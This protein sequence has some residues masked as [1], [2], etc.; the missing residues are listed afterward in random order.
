MFWQVDMDGVSVDSQP[1]LA[2]SSV[3]IDSGKSFVIISDP[4]QLQISVAIEGAQDASRAISPGF[5]T[6]PCSSST[7]AAR[8]SFG[9][10]P[11]DMSPHSFNLGTIDNGK[12]YVGSIVGRDFRG[13]ADWVVGDRFMLNA[14]AVFDIVNAQVGSAELA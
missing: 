12:N 13:V 5:F 8:L 11:F 10:K 9:E 2:K 14:Y 7:P 6:F 4:D 1:T 3:I